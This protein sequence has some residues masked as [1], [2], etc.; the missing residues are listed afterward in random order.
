MRKR[1]TSEL[2]RKEIDFLKHLEN[3][4]L[5]QKIE[6]EESTEH[7]IS[8]LSFFNRDFDPLEEHTERLRD[9]RDIIAKR[10]DEQLE[11]TLDY[12]LE[13][14]EDLQDTAESLG[15]NTN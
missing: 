4:Q 13:I 5:D 14:M 6:T 3:K 15:I 9:W 7:A 11:I 1:D 2:L 8:A 12:I 10:G